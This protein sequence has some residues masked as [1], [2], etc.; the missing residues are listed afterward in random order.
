[1]PRARNLAEYE[2][3]D[4]FVTEEGF[5]RGLAYTPHPTDVFVSPYAKCGTTWMQQIVHGLRS[6]GSMDFDEITEVTPWLE[7]AHDMGV[8]VNADQV[9]APRVFKS[10]L[11][12]D[13]IPKG[14]RYIIVLRD[15]VDAMV[16]LK[17][18]LDGWFIE[19]GSIS[20]DEF[21]QYY[22]TRGEDGYWAHAASWWGAREREDVLL[23]S[24][25]DMKTDLY[26]AVNQVADFMDQGYDDARRVLAT[27]QAQFEF[28]KAH[29]HQF[30]DNFLK[31]V[32]DPVVGL[33]TDSSSNKVSTGKTRA[34]VSDS[35]RTAFDQ[36]WD[37]TIGKEFGLA[38]YAE[39]RAELSQHP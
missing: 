5:A 33:P 18:F 17:R 16:S 1:M 12:W 30:D 21:A 27:R 38:S 32:H 28:M 22:L 7:L 15:P 29:A 3:L 6:A 26:K 11:R 34:Q 20:L 8:D 39:M 4:I 10:H 13:Q 37:A 2:A 25:E 24:F 35:I 14:G 23:L 36:H 9:A 31:R 19:E